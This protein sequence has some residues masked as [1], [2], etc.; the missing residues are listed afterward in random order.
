LYPNPVN[1]E[2]KI[3]LKNLTLGTLNVDIYN[4][5]GQIVRQ[6]YYS[7]I[8]S[9]EAVMTWDLSDNNGHS[10]MPGVYFVRIKNNETILVKKLIV[11]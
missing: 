11:N 6:L 5:V 1:I 7:S 3:S 9:R 10:V 2:S 4:Q 8:I